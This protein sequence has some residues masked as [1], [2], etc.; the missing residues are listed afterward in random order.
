[1]SSSI[2]QRLTRYGQ[3]LP[4]HYVRHYLLRGTRGFQ[5]WVV[6]FL[7]ILSYIIYLCV[8]AHLVIPRHSRQRRAFV[9]STLAL[10]ML[11]TLS[12]YFE[13]RKVLYWNTVLV[14]ILCHM[15]IQGYFKFT[16]LNIDLKRGHQ[17]GCANAILLY[18][19]SLVCNE[20]RLKAFG[21]TPRPRL[22]I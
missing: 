10:H 1:V 2:L 5:A 18:L 13:S 14:L 6:S 15:Y 7:I 19:K 11:Q 17:Q 20:H 12:C 8:Y 21:H 22:G 4:L 9:G 3:E 16:N